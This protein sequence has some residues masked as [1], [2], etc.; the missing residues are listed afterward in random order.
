MSD[1]IQKAVKILKSGGVIAFPTDTVY[2]IGCTSFNEKSVERIFKIKGRSFD[3]PLPIILSSIEDIPL[4]AKNV[5]ED[6]W[7]II[8]KYLPGPLTVVLEKTDLVSDIV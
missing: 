4:Y 3:K 7:R 2:G 8:K 5:S 6:A 1:I